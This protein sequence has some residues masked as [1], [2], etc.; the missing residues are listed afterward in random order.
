MPEQADIVLL[1]THSGDHYTVERVANAVASHGLQ[2]LRFDTDLFPSEIRLAWSMRNGSAHWLAHNG[3][4]IP[5]DRVC[6]V[7]LRKLW[8][9]MLGQTL[10]ERFREQCIKES[11]AALAG[12]LDS[13]HGALWIDHPDR[14]R[15]AE[16]KMHQLRVAAEVGLTIPRTLLT[17]DPDEVRQLY[18]DLGGNMVVK[19]LTPMSVSMDRPPAFVYTSSVSPADLAELDSLRY[20]PMVFQQRIEKA[21]ELRI[22]F[23]AGRLFAGSVDARQSAK[24]QTDWRLATADECRWTSAQV[25]DAV[26]GKLAALMHRLG[27]TFG[28]IDMIVTPA[29]EHVFLEVNPTGEWGMLERDVGHPISS[30]IADALIGNQDQP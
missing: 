30:A 13:L 26:R 29:A 27:L 23:V 19:M 28:A 9:P 14:V 15:Q 12:F 21:A 18:E 3:S 16:N 10:D 4:T 25:P 2:P 17:N 5:I 24:G 1:L 22:A 6:A 20:S 11:K 7:W 8:P